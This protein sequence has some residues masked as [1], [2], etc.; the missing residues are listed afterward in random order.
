MIVSSLCNKLMLVA[1]VVI[2]LRFMKDQTMSIALLSLVLMFCSY[3]SHSLL[4]VYH[5]ELTENHEEMRT[6]MMRNFRGLQILLLLE[7]VGSLAYHSVIDLEKDV[8]RWKFGYW[9]TQF[10]GDAQCGKGGRTMLIILDI[11][12]VYIVLLSTSYMSTNVEINTVD[13]K[14]NLSALDVERYGILSLLRMK[15]LDID[16]NSLKVTLDEFNVDLGDS[17]TNYN[18]MDVLDS[19]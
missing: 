17:Y 9:F 12:F 13:F 10:I 16:A 11:I 5:A 8:C 3:A 18:T 14:V 6:I 7:T 19:D 2:Y 1:Y 4:M 15:S